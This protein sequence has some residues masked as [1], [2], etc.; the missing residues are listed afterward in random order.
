MSEA[1]ALLRLQEIDL[2]LMRLN[3]QAEQLPQR[4]KVAAAKAA[5][6]KVAGE[7][8]KIVGQRKDLQIEMQDIADRRGRLVGYLAEAKSDAEVVTDYH[9][10]QMVELRMSRVTKQIEKADFDTDKLKDKLEV[11]ERAE[12][13]ARE[14]MER[15]EA[16]QRSQ[17]EQFREAS[18]E[19]TQKAAEL[20]SEREKL[21]REV[22]PELLDRY[23]KAKKRFGGLAVE[24]LTGNRPSACRVALQPS[25]FSDIRRGGDVTTC[26]YC[27]RILVV[28]EG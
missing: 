24:T 18:A 1:S 3:K 6:K 16:E 21:V 13:N 15:L 5:A 4:P 23:E 10:S 27:K 28:Q 20:T 9:E 11:V 8:T 26:P 22:S 14:L 12:K 19:I 2:T 17:M 7:L 25:S